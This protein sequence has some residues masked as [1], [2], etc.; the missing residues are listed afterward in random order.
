MKDY[1]K[2][3]RVEQYVKNLFVLSPLFLEA[4][5]VIGRCSFEPYWHSSLSLLRPAAFTSSMTFLTSTKT[6]RILKNAR[7]LWH[8]ALLGRETLWYCR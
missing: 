2:L 4:L 3:I 8:R 6:A 5:L 7:D 1:L